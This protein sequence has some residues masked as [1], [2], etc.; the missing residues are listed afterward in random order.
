VLLA[1]KVI[2]NVMDCSMFLLP[3]MPGH[4][5]EHSH[6][7][8]ITGGGLPGHAANSVPGLPGGIR[9]R[10]G[11]ASLHACLC[12]GFLPLFNTSCS[13]WCMGGCAMVYVIREA[14]DTGAV[15]SYPISPCT[16]PAGI[17]V[18]A[19]AGNYQEPQLPA[20]QYACCHLRLPPPFICISLAG[21]VVVAAAGNYQ[22][23]LL[24]YLPAACRTVAAVTA[25]DPSSGAP[26]AF[27]NFLPAD[28]SDAQK[29]RVIA[30]P[31]SGVLSTISIQRESSRY[32]C[33]Q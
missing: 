23:S 9:C 14:S 16:S 27:T 8:V 32:R 7:R 20:S 5:P 31:G 6:I 26:S 3:V 19:A 4:Q 2:T 15:L 17:H 11:G 24:N 30:A 25:V 21:I 13:A 18:V 22:E 1:D 29:A 28:A 33:G 12:G 10:C